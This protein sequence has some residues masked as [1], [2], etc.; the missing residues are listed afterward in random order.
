MT[1]FR[2][3]ERARCRQTE[4]FMIARIWHGR[5]NRAKADEYL[6]FLKRRALP[7]YRRTTGNL[8]AYILRRAERDITHFLTITHWES[9]R[10]IEAF[11]GKDV[12]RAKYYPEDSA[13]LLEFEPTVQ[14]HELYS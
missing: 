6:D 8:A 9:L 13:F 3:G 10:A 4:D 1:N 2:R 11:A 12:A 7:D 14:H 5:T